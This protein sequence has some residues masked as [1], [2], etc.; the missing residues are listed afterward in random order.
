MTD[1][2]EII[3]K[4][5]SKITEVQILYKY[6]E[7]VYEELNKYTNLMM[8]IKTRIEELEGKDGDIKNIS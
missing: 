8:K 5:I 3:D 2:L 1:I 7:F 6:R 4:E